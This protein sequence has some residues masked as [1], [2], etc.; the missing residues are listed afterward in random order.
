MANTDSAQITALASSS[1]KAA[2]N[3]LSGRL[4]VAYFSVA[5][6]PVV[7]IGDTMT[8]T[9]LPKGAK[10]LRGS[11]QFTVAQGA[12]ATMA[13]GIAGSTGKYR[14]AATNNVTTSEDFALVAA[15]NMGNDTTAEETIIATN[16]GATWTASA[17]RGYIIYI[18]D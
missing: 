10:V 2:S 9:K 14:A 17:F 6:V 5:A 16:A 1:G 4:R 3:E 13:L 12:T 8:L 7:G 15:T 11:F 18:V